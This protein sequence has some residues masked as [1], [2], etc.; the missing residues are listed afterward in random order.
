SVASGSGLYEAALRK[1][2]SLG[3]SKSAR[4]EVSIRSTLLDWFLPASGRG[5][6]WGKASDIQFLVNLEGCRDGRGPGRDVPGGTEAGCGSFHIVDRGR[7]PERQSNGAQR[8]IIGN[9]ER[10]EN[11]RR[12]L[13][14]RVAGR[15]GGG[16]H[17]RARLQHASAGDAREQD[18]Q[19]IG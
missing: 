9:S 10:P 16:K 18:V 1:Q 3:M 5:R 11:L 4:C 13:A 8:G 17:A 15:T 7:P 19:R 6:A 14:V 2:T 12:G